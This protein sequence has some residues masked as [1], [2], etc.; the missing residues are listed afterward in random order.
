MTEVDKAKYRRLR[1]H[2]LSHKEAVQMAATTPNADFDG[3]RESERATYVRVV[4]GELVGPDDE[5]IEVGGGALSKLAAGMY[6]QTA[7]GAYTV[8]SGWSED[9]V[10]GTDIDVVG[11]DINVAAGD[12]L[13]NFSVVLDGSSDHT[14][15]VVEVAGSDGNYRNAGVIATAVKPGSDS[16]VVRGSGWFSMAA[17]GEVSLAVTL[18][19]GATPDGTSSASIDL[20]RLG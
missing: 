10:T 8:L 20:V 3:D 19:G 5:V 16:W 2:G 13:L 4:D 12:Y 7:L 11:G 17:A 14:L 18:A 6:D 15:A 9:A 1:A